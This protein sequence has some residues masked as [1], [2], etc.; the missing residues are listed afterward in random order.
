[1]GVAIAGT[2]T[3][4]EPRCMGEREGEFKMSRQAHN[5]KAV[6]SNP[7]PATTEEFLKSLIVLRIFSCRRKGRLGDLENNLDLTCGHDW[8]G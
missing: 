8:H 6:G 3:G 1:M 7:T 5:L 4:F 2:R